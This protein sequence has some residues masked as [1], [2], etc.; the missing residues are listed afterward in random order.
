MR[1]IAKRVRTSVP[2]DEFRIFPIVTN[3]FAGLSPGLTLVA[4]GVLAKALS[5]Q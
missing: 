5:R 1:N 4:A 2:N 3:L